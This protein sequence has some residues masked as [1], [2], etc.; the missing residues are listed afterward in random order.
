M[1]G[2][3]RSFLHV[4]SA[5]LVG[6]VAG[7]TSRTGSL[8]A[9]TGAEST[10]A[11]SSSTPT[12]TPTSTPTSTATGNCDTPP[13]T[14]MQRVRGDAVAVNETV[15]DENVEYLP[16]TDEVRYVAAWRALGPDEVEEGE[17]PHRE[18]EYETVPF[19]EWADVESATIAAKHARDVVG[20]TLP[21]DAL[22]FGV[23]SEN[24]GRVVLI[25]LEYL[26][27]R[28]GTVISQPAEDV[29]PDA[30]ADAAPEIVDVSFT[31]DE[32]EATRSVPVYVRRVTIHQE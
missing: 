17:T 19:D 2:S 4:A 11:E 3:R 21:T 32:V 12:D 27:D 31:F 1:R 20:E 14:D 8:A 28:S 13:N 22:S 16:K 6:I 9:S 25:H 24:G 26:C 23:T 15:T 30:V 18:A 29:T 5:G 7:C 10:T